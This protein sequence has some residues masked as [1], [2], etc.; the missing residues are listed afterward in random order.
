MLAPRQHSSRKPQRLEQ[1]TY[2]VAPADHL[3]EQY[4]GPLAQPVDQ[5]EQSGMPT[6]TSIPVLP[7]SGLI[8]NR[9]YLTTRDSA[10]L[11]NESKAF[12]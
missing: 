7:Q 6:Y 9:K 4:R 10:N 8:M 5:A 3:Y 1:D 2:A 11:P 12:R